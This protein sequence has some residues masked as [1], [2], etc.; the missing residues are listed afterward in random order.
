MSEVA[1]FIA[2]LNRKTI[3]NIYIEPTYDSK[4][5]I[6][7]SDGA[8]VYAW[9][10]LQQCCEERYMATGDDL[11]AFIGADLINLEIRSGSGIVADND[12]KWA[13]TQFLLVTTSKGVFTITNYNAHNGYYGGFNLAVKFVDALII[14][15]MSGHY[16]Y[17]IFELA[18]K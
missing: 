1:D 14:D 2:G 8:H 7:F 11:T 18:V 17:A 6:S 12:W 5:V 15:G 4:L 13:D 10:D 9:D 3:E 16:G